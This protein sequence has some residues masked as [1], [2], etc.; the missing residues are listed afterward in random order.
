M[1]DIDQWVSSTSYSDFRRP[2]R[3]LINFLPTNKFNPYF[4][5][6]ESSPG[7]I[8]TFGLFRKWPKF[9]F[10]GW[11]HFRISLTELTKL[12]S[13]RTPEGQYLLARIQTQIIAKVSI[14]S[15]E[16]QASDLWFLMLI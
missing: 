13:N 10:R 6:W 4:P 1:L 7:A 16:L 8:F 3:N 9:S 14:L 15:L 2:V 11:Q 12:R 5:A